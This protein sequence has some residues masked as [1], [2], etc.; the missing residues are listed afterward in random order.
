MFS[1]FPKEKIVYKAAVPIRTKKT[2]FG[3]VVLTRAVLIFL[4]VEL[5]EKT[6]AIGDRT[7]WL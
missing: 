7:A 6:F 4:A 3:L 1:W 2:K 5:S